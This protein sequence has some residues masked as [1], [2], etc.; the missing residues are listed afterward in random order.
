[1]HQLNGGAAMKKGHIVKCVDTDERYLTIG[2]E[3]EIR[4]GQG[5]PDMFGDYVGS[6]RSFEIMSDEGKVLF[7]IY[8]ECAHAKWELVS[9]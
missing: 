1:M 7:A 9:E 8:P 2:R 4:S 6:D 3:Y 5:D